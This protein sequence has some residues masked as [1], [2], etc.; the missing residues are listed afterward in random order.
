VRFAPEPYRAFRNFLATFFLKCK[1]GFRFSHE[2]LHDL[3]LSM[4]FV[5]DHLPIADYSL[6]SWF[7]WQEL[8]KHIRIQ[9]LSS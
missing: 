9:S 2:P 7:F 6:L 3:L 8:N 1:H 5:N 4:P